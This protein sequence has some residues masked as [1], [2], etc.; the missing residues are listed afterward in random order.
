VSIDDDLRRRN[1]TE[2]ASTH[3]NTTS[4]SYVNSDNARSSFESVTSYQIRVR[5]SDRSKEPDPHTRQSERVVTSTKSPLKLR[6]NSGYN[7]PK[8]AGVDSAYRAS[9]GSM[10]MQVSSSQ[11]QESVQ[12][13]QAR[14]STISLSKPM[15]PSFAKPNSH[16]E[17]N[18]ILSNGTFGHSYMTGKLSP[19]VV[20]VYDLNT[21]PTNDLIDELVV[22]TARDSNKDFD[23][24]GKDASNPIF[25]YL[26]SNNFDSMPTNEDHFGK[27][28]YCK[29]EKEE[30]KSGSFHMT[31]VDG[32]LAEIASTFH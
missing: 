12:P 13:Y 16:H 1:T 9:F 2:A 29:N 5:T 31:D 28:S 6:G 8:T 26:Q 11:A 32:L 17:S 10:F 19:R 30:D 15:A 25:A 21:Y 3:M 7:P 23:L 24:N 14:S 18:R 22:N 20:E 27:M 4:T